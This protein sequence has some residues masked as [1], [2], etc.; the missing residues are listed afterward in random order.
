MTVFHFLFTILLF[1]ITYSF[2][3][4]AGRTHYSA[5]ML[6]TS[7][8]P[9]ERKVSETLCLSLG[10]LKGF[11]CFSVFIITSVGGQL[12]CDLD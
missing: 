10:E 5:S 2:S 7:N 6:V 3:L 4:V 11:F 9:M 12:E 8:F 1:N